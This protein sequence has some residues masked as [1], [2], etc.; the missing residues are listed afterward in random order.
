MQALE[1]IPGTLTYGATPVP[2][3]VSWSGE[4][5]GFE[6]RPC[7]FADGHPA[8]CQAEA[9][10]IGSPRFGSPHWQRQRQAIA[11]DL[12]DLCGKPLKAR[13]KVS[14]S[15]ARPRFNGADGIAVLQVEPLLHRECAKISME[16]CP[17]LRRGIRD[18]SIEV[19]QVLRSRAQFAIIVPSA[20]GEY[21]AGYVAGGSERIIGHAKVEL[22]R[23]RDRNADWLSRRPT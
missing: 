8:L 19:R 5:H 20:V 1:L 23:W 3:T 12:C 9:P 22:L 16:F 17:K 2:F 6:V 7:R 10:G 4:E 14:L 13:T 15:D 21:V 11:L 18:G